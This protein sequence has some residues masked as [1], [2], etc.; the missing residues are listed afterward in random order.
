MVAHYTTLSSIID[1]DVRNEVVTQSERYREVTPSPT[2][3]NM[4]TAH[5]CLMHHPLCWSEGSAADICGGA[6]VFDYRLNQNQPNSLLPQPD[7]LTGV[8][9][10]QPCKTHCEQVRLC[11]Y[12][13]ELDCSSL[14]ADDAAAVQYMHPPMQHSKA[15]LRPNVCTGNLPGEQG[16]QCSDLPVMLRY[17]YSMWKAHGVERP[18][19]DR[20]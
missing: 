16:S 7:P 17:P 6:C 19:H 3:T 18:H 1:V 11:G 8:V 12:P 15:C 13:I 20:C 10:I 2:C 4:W 9:Q 14:H 5:Q